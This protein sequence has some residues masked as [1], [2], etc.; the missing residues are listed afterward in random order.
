MSRLALIAILLISIA[1]AQTPLVTITVPGVQQVGSGASWITPGA[2]PVG[3]KVK[4]DGIE[5]TFG[6]FGFVDNVSQ[7]SVESIAEFTVN[8]M[9]NRAEFGGVSSI[10][11]V[12][13]AGTNQ[14]HADVFYYV[15]NS[16]LDSRNTFQ[17]ARAFT[18]L[19]NYGIT[20]GGPIRK[21]KTFATMTF[22]GARG[23]DP[24][25]VN[26]SVPTAP[27]RPGAFPGP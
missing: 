3:V 20:A 6:N 26:A 11:S 21:D 24:Y 19:H 17:P 27:R 25:T 14:L 7:P 8:V 10:T 5:T 9:T 1:L 4:V 12:T 13:K 18:N 15:R 16:A 23:V 2:Q 22:D